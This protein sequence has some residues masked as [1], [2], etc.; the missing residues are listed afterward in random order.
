[1]WTTKRCGVLIVAVVFLMTGCTH[2]QTLYP[3]AREDSDVIMNVFEAAT[4][5][6]ALGDDAEIIDMNRTHNQ[7][8]IEYDL[9]VRELNMDD[10]VSVVDVYGDEKQ[11]PF[12]YLAKQSTSALLTETGWEAYEDFDLDNFS[13]WDV[14]NLMIVEPTLIKEQWPYIDL[15]HIDIDPFSEYLLYSVNR[16]IKQLSIYPG[17][18]G[19]LQIKAESYAFG[20]LGYSS[21]NKTDSSHSGLDGRFPPDSLRCILESEYYPNTIFIYK[22]SHDAPPFNMTDSQCHIYWEYMQVEN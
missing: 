15:T 8:A 5:V 7:F 17:Q 18:F 16:K 22:I 6:Q 9:Y 12:M 19:D 11:V 10:Y 2:E 4:Y 13:Y 1:M 3:Q 20:A 14:V 21:E